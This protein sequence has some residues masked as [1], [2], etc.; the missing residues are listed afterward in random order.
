MYFESHVHL[1]DK[2]YNE[3]RDAEI[4]QNFKNGVTKV[5]NVGADM[6]SSDYS[7]KLSEKY[8]FIYATVGVHPHDVKNMTDNDLNMLKEMSKNQKVVG[9]GEIGLDYFY[10]YSNK[11]DQKKWFIEQLKLAMELDLPVVIHSRD[12]DN[13]CYEIIKK[14]CPKK[15]V[16]HCFSGS[17]ELAKQ[18]VDLGYY[19]GVGGVV[20]FKNARKLVEVVRNIPLE[21][22]LIE[23]DGPYLTPEPH[24]GERNSSSYLKY[25]AEKIANIKEIPVEK[26]QETTYLNGLSFYGIK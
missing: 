15:A 16:I 9:I 11:K 20:T 12:A 3:D 24:R 7:I 19:I 5:V 1:D 10:E 6:K 14:Y 22:I 2:R 17:S 8:D 26:V 21:S 25:V 4:K 23:T 18:Y 13:E